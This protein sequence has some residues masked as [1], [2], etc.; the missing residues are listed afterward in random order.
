MNDIKTV[1]DEN[2]ALSD[3][4]SRQCSLMVSPVN[5]RGMY[6]VAFVGYDFERFSNAQSQRIIAMSLNSAI[7]EIT[8]EQD[9][10]A[11]DFIKINDFPMSCEIS[12]LKD[13]TSNVNKSQ[14][15]QLHNYHPTMN[16]KQVDNPQLDERLLNT[17]DT[18]T[19]S[20]LSFE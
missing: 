18:S 7:T 3:E 15:V 16:H 6:S 2:L 4:K 10:K 19:S 20:G 13:Y 17:P 5:K 12:E 14:P 1:L 9:Y 11:N 8:M